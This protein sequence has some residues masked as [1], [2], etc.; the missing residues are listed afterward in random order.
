MR[1]SPVRLADDRMGD[2]LA[3]TEFRN[4][5]TMNGR[6]K[7]VESQN[8]L[9]NL[10]HQGQPRSSIEDLNPGSQ[11]LVWAHVKNDTGRYG[12]KLVDARKADGFEG[13]SGKIHAVPEGAESK[14]SEGFNFAAAAGRISHGAGERSPGRKAIAERCIHTQTFW[15]QDQNGDGGRL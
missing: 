7:A 4:G 8:N 10:N 11:K 6:G 12:M 3:Q 2:L 14:S 1:L 9:N 13:S 15:V 5:I